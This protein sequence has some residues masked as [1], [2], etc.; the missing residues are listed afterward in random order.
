MLTHW[1]K[2]FPASPPLD[3]VAG[4]RYKKREGRLHDVVFLSSC[5]LAGIP[6]TPRQ[7]RKWNNDKG[8]AVRFRNEAKSGL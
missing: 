5:E 1:W 4:E 7:A 2:A 6:A 8:L 3:V